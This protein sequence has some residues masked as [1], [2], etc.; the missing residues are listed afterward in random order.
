MG[1]G[2]RTRSA[3]WTS[4]YSS[5]GDVDSVAVDEVG[6]VRTGAQEVGGGAGALQREARLGESG[7]FPSGAGGAPD[8][9]DAGEP[10]PVGLARA[11]ADDLPVGGLVG[12]LVREFDQ[13]FPGF[14]KGWIGLAPDSEDDTG[15]LELDECGDE[16]VAVHAKSL[17]HG[18]PWIAFER[19]GDRHA[20]QGSQDMGVLQ[21]GLNHRLRVVPPP[22]EVKGAGDHA[23]FYRAGA[24]ILSGN[25]NK[26]SGGE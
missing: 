7:G 4:S 8:G 26:R 12:V 5:G 10:A 21:Q 25:S 2:L 16:D 24:G 11:P 20:S 15:L 1:I 6:A 3:T 9:G 18:S 17:R 23:W 13:C 22:E 14:H 19:H